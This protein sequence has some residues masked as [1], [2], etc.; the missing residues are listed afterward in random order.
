M[1]CPDVRVSISAALDGEAAPLPPD[2]VAHHLDRCDGCRRFAEELGDLHRILRVQP[3]PEEPDRT[4]A[5]VAALPTRRS[6]ADEHL[7]GLRLVT[8]L[9]ALVQVATAAPLLFM[10]DAMGHMERHIGISSVAMAVGLAFVA[11][12]PWRARAMLPVL[13]VLAVGLVWSCFGDIW[14]GRPVPGNLWAH[15][16]DV[17]GFAAVWLLSRATG[18]TDAIPR[19]A[20]LR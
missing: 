7:L 20:V 12:R 1:T 17:A 16:A 3:A 10:S 9:I 5:I 18:A 15:G 2:V 8:L 13:G 4:S 11:L 19:R 14:A 6:A